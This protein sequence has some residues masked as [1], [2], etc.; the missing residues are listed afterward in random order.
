[1]PMVLTLCLTRSGPAQGHAIATPLSECTRHGVY[2]RVVS[3]PRMWFQRFQTLSRSYEIRISIHLR[4][5][6]SRFMLH[7]VL[8]GYLEEAGC[9]AFVHGLVN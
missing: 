4:S 1:M 8:H 6:Q 7:P 5:R 9:N 2:K 3:H